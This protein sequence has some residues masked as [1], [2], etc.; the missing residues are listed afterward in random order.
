MIKRWYRKIK[1]IFNEFRIERSYYLDFTEEFI[2][3]DD[4]PGYRAGRLEI[5]NGSLSPHSLE[6]Q[7]VFTKNFNQFNKDF[8]KVMWK[9]TS[10]ER[11]REIL[12]EFEK[13][14]DVGIIQEKMNL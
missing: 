3:N 10:K 7:R 14:Y 11:L 12:K 6:E 8:E 9:E 4:F 2:M 13:Y 5:R 1:H